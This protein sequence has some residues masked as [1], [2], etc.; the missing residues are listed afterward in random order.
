[1]AARQSMVTL[2][3]EARGWTQTQLAANAVMSQA[4]ISK[5][6]TGA[7]EL[8][9]ERLARLAHALD[10]PPDFLERSADLPSI[11][12][13]CLH[14]R[15]ASTMTVNTMKRIEAVTHLSRISVEGLLSGIELAPARTFERIEIMD[16]R[17]PA[18]IAGELR[19]RWSTPNGPIRNL[20]GLVESA[21]VVI[22][23]R[24]FGTTGQ[25]AVSTWPEDP[26]RPPMMLINTDLPSDRLRFT[27]AHEFGHLVMHRLPT[28]NQEAEANS[29]AGEFLAPA[30]EIRHE[31]EGLRTSDF[32]RLMALKIEWGMSMAALIRRAHDLETITDRQYREF[33]VRLGKLGWRTSE[34]GDVAR[35]S[36]SIV[37][38]I[39]ALQRRE[40]EYSDDELARL[41]G[42]TEP[43]FQRYFLADPG[44]SGQP[45][46]RLDL[47]E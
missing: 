13:T 39:I 14:R 21:G 19:R 15:R 41:A 10:C 3:R 36:P 44:S 6:E 5:V 46:L 26:G 34:P 12:I 22:V 11:E 23:F 30:D 8:D 45:P 28:D 31:L 38:K 25:D 9:P 35:E 29:F 43:A 2:M 32:R 42:M 47:H 18:A 33:Q 1:M 40:H 16:D 37:N 7:L 17:G 4:V 27:V 24:S 20:I